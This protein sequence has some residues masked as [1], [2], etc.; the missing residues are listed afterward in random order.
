[1]SLLEALSRLQEE[2]PL[3]RR[4][5]P[6]RVLLQHHLQREHAL[7]QQSSA[8][9]AANT[10]DLPR[11]WHETTHARDRGTSM[12]IGSQR[13][14][15][16]EEMFRKARLRRCFQHIMQAK[17]HHESQG[18]SEVSPPSGNDNLVRRPSHIEAEGVSTLDEERSKRLHVQHEIPSERARSPQPEA[19]HPGHPD[20][21]LEPIPPEGPMA[22]E[23][24]PL[25]NRDESEEAAERAERRILLRR[26]FHAARR[27]ERLDLGG[28]GN[29][30]GPRG[31]PCFTVGGSGMRP[32]RG[33][34]R[35][36]H[37]GFNAEF[38]GSG[39]VGLRRA[40]LL[41]R[42]LHAMRESVREQALQADA[43]R[44]PPSPVPA[45]HPLRSPSLPDSQQLRQDEPSPTDQPGVSPLP[46]P[47]QL[48]TNAPDARRELLPVHPRQT[49]RTANA[50]Q[51][52]IQ[53]LTGLLPTTTSSDVE[54]ER[55]RGG[56]GNMH[57][58]AVRCGIQCQGYIRA[59]QR[60][61]QVRACSPQERFW[62]D[63]W[64]NVSWGGFDIQAFT[65]LRQR[66]PFPPQ[67]WRLCSS[68]QRWRPH[69][70]PCCVRRPSLANH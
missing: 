26:F 19:L 8:P 11:P 65:T 67:Q 59:L 12:A 70:R 1:M 39:G 38:V 48:S 5:A 56:A 2:L 41:R 47:G 25:V 36:E 15:V 58:A 14:K 52:V 68:Q 10:L 45:E 17:K 57:A 46:T 62:R 37:Q 55:G 18:L 3:A 49:A 40:E 20:D 13:A 51:A 60:G 30:S 35:R 24:Q 61:I 50:Y 9:E 21:A 31:A 4:S 66:S 22:A 33:R 53:A 23:E 69:Q 27:D 7:L 42:I 6:K 28:F 34:A 43:S 32:S 29:S 63:P 16:V 54:E 44:A 64:C